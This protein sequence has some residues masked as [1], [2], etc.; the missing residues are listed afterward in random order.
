MVVFGNGADDDNALEAFVVREGELVRV[1]Q[2]EEVR[3]Q[4]R[5]GVETVYR[6]GQ[7]SGP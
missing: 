1:Q 5:T 2:F 4:T 3:K 7:K 6:A